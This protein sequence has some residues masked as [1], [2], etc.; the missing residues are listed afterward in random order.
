MIVDGR[1]FSR[2]GVLQHL[3]EAALFGLAGK[4]GNPKRLRLADICWQLRQHRHATRDME[5]ADTNWKPGLSELPSEVDSARKLVR[6]HADKRNQ[7]PSARLAN[8]SDNA[9][10]NYPAVCLVIDA[11][12]N[13]DIWPQNLAVLGI[14]RKSVQTSKR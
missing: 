14:F 6:L 12:T 9:R 2:K 8:F 4:Q 1:Q 7:R 11:E 10:R 3:I 13:L 5:S